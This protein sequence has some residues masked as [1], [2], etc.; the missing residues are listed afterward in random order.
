VEVHVTAGD[1]AQ[2]C[3]CNASP[4]NGYFDFHVAQLKAEKSFD[5]TVKYCKHKYLVFLNISLVWLLTTQNKEYVKYYI[6][7][8]VYCTHITHCNIVLPFSIKRY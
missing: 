1:S 8:N 5:A 7:H 6:P 2:Y 4:E 3:S